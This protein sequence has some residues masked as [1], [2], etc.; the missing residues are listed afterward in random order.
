MR[1]LASSLVVLATLAASA[2]ASDEPA[3][4]SS[5]FTPSGRPASGLAA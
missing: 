2:C 1:G 5:S 3:M 4:L